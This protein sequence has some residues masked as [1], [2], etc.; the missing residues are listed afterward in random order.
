MPTKWSL[1]INH[2]GLV[3]YPP[4]TTFGPRT[5]NDYEFVWI[6]RG[7]CI[8]ETDGTKINCS[9][10][11]VILCRPGMRDRFIWD[12]KQTVRHGYIHFDLTNERDADDAESG[13]PRTLICSDQD[14]LRPLLRHVVWLHSGSNIEGKH[15]A[16]DSLG[17]ALNCY[18][19]GFI[20]QNGR[21]PADHFHP[22]LERAF[23][24][25]HEF[26]TVSKKYYSPKIEDWASA[27]AI[28]RGHFIRICVEELGVTPQQL[29]RHIR[30][31]HSLNL[32]CRTDLSI[33]VISDTC[34]FAN[35]YHYS[36]C[37]TETYG[38]SPR[39]L[40]AQLRD[41]KSAPASAIAPRKRI[42]MQ[43]FA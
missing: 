19:V 24:A 6:E 40:R 13:W 42:V 38:L 25:L 28:S 36:R 3:D 12:T 30:L 15:L 37:C 21:T 20:E 8:W 34:G 10:G 14:I 39:E 1:K 43:L 22:A 5:L 32:L 23:L 41:G 4:G 27:A 16:V 11:T 18:L 9:V 17:H 7:E 26:W 35:P 29:L 33:A 31:D 2:S